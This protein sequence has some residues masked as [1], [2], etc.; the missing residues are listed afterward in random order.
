MPLVIRC[1][2]CSRKLRVPEN[3]LGKKVKCPSCAGTFVSQPESEDLPAAP[4]PD[5]QTPRGSKRRPAGPADEEKYEMEPVPARRRS[6]P[7]GDDDYEE[8]ERPEEEEYEER[9]RPR[10]RRRRLDMR[11]HRGTMILVL[12]ILS[13]FCFGI[14]L[15]PIAWVMGS[16][17][18]KEMRAGRMDPE[19]E[20]L[21]NAGRICG[22]I[23]A[24]L[25]FAGCLIYAIVFA[26]AGAGRVIR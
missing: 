23:A 18:L 19:G 12:G 14:I 20:G 8:E 4:L 22:M 3:L 24:I 1:P 10:R 2:S 7:P 13:F 11:P 5:E 16:N 9:P 25:N 15:G 6:S 21:T 26:L 17:D